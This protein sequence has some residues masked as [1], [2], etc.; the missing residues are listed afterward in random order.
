MLRSVLYRMLCSRQ[1]ILAV[2]CGVI[3]HIM[4]L[5]TMIPF[6]LQNQNDAVYY[7]DYSLGFGSFSFLLVLA[8]AIS[9]GLTFWEETTAYNHRFIITRGSKEEYITSRVIA[10]MIVSA[11]CSFVIFAITMAVMNCFVPIV[12]VTEERILLLQQD[13]HGYLWKQQTP[14]LYFAFYALIA[15]LNGALWGLVS[16]VTSTYTENRFVIL[17]CPIVVSQAIDI[18]LSLMNA[19]NAIQPYHL[20]TGYFVLGY[21]MWREVGWLC[22]IYS[23]YYIPMII[24]FVKRAWRYVYE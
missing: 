13:F 20:M 3:A 1:L 21:S 11:V 22:I 14:I 8:P 4:N 5:G 16:L 2:L 7:Y 15:G 12:D 6:I 10:V 18:A 24:L 9:S 19:P 23:A 17:A